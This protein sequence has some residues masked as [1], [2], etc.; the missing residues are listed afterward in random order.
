[1]DWLMGLQNLVQGAQTNPQA[2]AQNAAM[3]GVDPA[4]IEQL[5]QQQLG[6]PMQPQQP[7][8]TTGGQPVENPP[9]SFDNMFYGSG[10]P[11]KPGFSQ[12]PNPGVAMQPGTT[13]LP[14]VGPP[15]QTAVPDP[16]ASPML[17][18]AGDGGPW[19]VVQEG[20]PGTNDKAGWDKVMQAGPQAPG[21]T[22]EQLAKIA[23]M[24]PRGG[25]QA[26][27]ASAQGA[28][29]RG[30]AAPGQLSVAAIRRPSL[31][32]ILSGGR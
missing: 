13:T 28:G 19:S 30:V 23:G 26:P 5:L 18:K 7:G 9:Q 3:R 14:P 32:Q 16:Q 8:Q 17:P 4:G 24:M 25:V 11:M 21:L 22:P 12:T 15:T 31:A 20:L 1:M 27:P 10:G 2:F 29:G 6:L